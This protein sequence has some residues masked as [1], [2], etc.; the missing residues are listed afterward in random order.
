MKKIEGDPTCGTACPEEGAGGNWLRAAPGFD[1]A[2]L[3]FCRRRPIL[4]SAAVR[5]TMTRGRRRVGGTAEAR[6]RMAS[7]SAPRGYFRLAFSA[8]P[9]AAIPFRATG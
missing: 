7:A 3:H 6:R 2:A 5:E 8:V 4:R 1:R 9:R